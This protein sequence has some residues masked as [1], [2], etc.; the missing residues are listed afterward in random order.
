MVVKGL[1]RK[2]DELQ[3]ND[4][5]VFNHS[6][7]LYTALKPPNSF[8]NSFLTLITLLSSDATVLKST[9]IMST[10]M[11]EKDTLQANKFTPILPLLKQN[12]IKVSS[13]VSHLVAGLFNN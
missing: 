1:E 9:L 10:H 7:R 5:Q 4:L 6:D 12:T 13:F 11:M 2:I 8:Q 3:R